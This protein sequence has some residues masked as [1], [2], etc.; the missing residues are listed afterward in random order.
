VPMPLSWPF[1]L[2]LGLLQQTPAHP[3][4]EDD[5]RIRGTVVD[6]LSALP[7]KAARVSVTS[8]NVPSRTASVLTQADGRFVFENLEPGKYVLSAKCK[9]Y[10]EQMFQQHE[11]FRTAVVVG[12]DLDSQ[13]LVLQLVRSASLVGQVTDEF[14]DGVRGAQVVLF[15]EGIKNGKVSIHMERR[16]PTDDEGHYRFAG[17]Q[18]GRYYLAVAAQPWYAQANTP[19]AGHEDANTA[20]GVVASSPQSIGEQNK[21]LDVVYPLTYFPGENDAAKAS[22]IILQAGEHAS[23]D[24]AMRSV[25]A[26]H[27]RLVAPGWDLTQPAGIRM[28]QHTFDGQ[29]VFVRPRVASKS[30]EYIELAGIPP[31]PLIINVDVYVGIV[32]G[33]PRYSWR[34][35]IDASPHPQVNL[36]LADAERGA[37]VS[38]V[39]KGAEASGLPQPAAI[40]IHESESGAT[41]LATVSK[42]GNFAFPNAAVKS[43]KYSMSLRNSSGFYVKSVQPDGAAASAH[44]FEVRGAEPLRLVVE[45]AQGSGRVEG[46]ALL[47]AK[48]VPGAMIL[49]VP[50]DWQNDPSLYQRDQS[51]SDGSFAIAHV[52]PGRYTILAIENGW[53]QEWG[54]PSLLNRWLSAGQTLQVTPNGKHT[55]QVKVQ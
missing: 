27:L 53:A 21:H 16:A 30:R 18:P 47:D 43:G 35:E 38:G 11:N 15:R 52:P 7:L 9:G 23:A 17:L 3:S 19:R 1:I 45:V 22:A 50:N 20:S 36:N 13:N 41:Q 5:F 46:V 37:T 14:S 24:L 40:A 33:K 2:L 42:T 4:E 6:A 34:K 48:P 10:E 29:E 28:A 54:N 32:D 8:I 26:L 51:D 44:S 55:I 39:V 31:G 12:R 25:P 49:L